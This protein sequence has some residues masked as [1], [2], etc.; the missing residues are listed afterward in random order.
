MEDRMFT[1]SD[2]RKTVKLVICPLIQK[3][4]PRLQLCQKTHFLQKESCNPL[5]E[6]KCECESEN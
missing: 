3:E 6:K 1:Q 5:S 4:D 2:G